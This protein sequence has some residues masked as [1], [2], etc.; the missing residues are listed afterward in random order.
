MIVTYANYLTEDKIMTV[1]QACSDIIRKIILD[2]RN[3]LLDCPERSDLDFV[4]RLIDCLPLTDMSEG[5]RSTIIR[6]LDFISYA[7][8]TL[9]PFTYVELLG[10]IETILEH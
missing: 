3:G 5:D 4:Y 2:L 1:A 6:I 10:D 7:P 9:R 8:G